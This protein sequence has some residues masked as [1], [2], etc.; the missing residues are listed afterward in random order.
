MRIV[1]CK[2]GAEG[3]SRKTFA[4]TGDPIYSPVFRDFCSV[5]ILLLHRHGAAVAAGIVSP[6]KLLGGLSEPQGKTRAGKKGHRSSGRGRFRSALSARGHP[7]ELLCRLAPVLSRP[8]VF[9]DRY[10]AQRLCESISSGS[11]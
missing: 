9:L 2:A 10:V 3:G 1:P 4:A 5:A 11:R 6:G 8:A 7:G